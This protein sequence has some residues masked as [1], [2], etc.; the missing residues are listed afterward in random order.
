MATGGYYRSDGIQNSGTALKHG[1]VNT[2]IYNSS[3]KIYPRQITSSFTASTPTGGYICQ[4]CRSGYNSNY[5]KGTWRTDKAYQGFYNNYDG[6]SCKSCGHF[7]SADSQKINI[8]GGNILNFK[9]TY[10]KI[11]MN[12]AKRR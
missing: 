3:G 4:T 2:E 5:E 11:T 7:F 1:N 12:R 8:G 10:V 9:I 6:Q